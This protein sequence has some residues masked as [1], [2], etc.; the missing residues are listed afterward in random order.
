[1]SKS[2]G[3]VV[4]PDVVLDKQGADAVRWFFCINSAPWIPTRFSIEAVDE[5][6][7]KFLNTL[8]NTY[9]FYVLYADIHEFNPLKYKLD[10]KDLSEMDRWVLSRLNTVIDTVDKNLEKYEITDFGTY[11]STPVDYPDFVHPVAS[12][13]ENSE[14]NFGIL[15]CGSGQGVSITANKHQKIRCA[16]CWMPE[17][18]EL[19]RQHNDANMLALSARFIAKELA[20]EIT[21]KFLTTVFE[22]GRHEKRVKKIA[23]YLL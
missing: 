7:K 16:L 5:V 13:I 15:V 17:L 22:G 10:E 11:S 8:W 4:D 1:M 12:S 21:E 9:A 23:C 20:L 2:K 3:N 19:A 18:A 14:N 6:Q